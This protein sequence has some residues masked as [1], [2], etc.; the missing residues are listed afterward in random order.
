LYDFPLFTKAECYDFESN[1]CISWSIFLEN[2]IDRAP[3]DTGLINELEVLLDSLL[4]CFLKLS[5]ELSRT[6]HK[7]CKQRN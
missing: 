6:I 3:S 2:G 7:K 4:R 5:T 1:I